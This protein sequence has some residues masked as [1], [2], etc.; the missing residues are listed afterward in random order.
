MEDTQMGVISKETCWSIHNRTMITKRDDLS[1]VLEL[2][3]EYTTYK[4]KNGIYTK[5]TFK[6][7]LPIIFEGVTPAYRFLDLLSYKMECKAI[8]AT[9]Q[10]YNDKNDAF[11]ISSVDHLRKIMSD[12]KIAS[13]LSWSK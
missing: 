2:T 1:N 7:T 5:K 13:S 8:P 11:C 10:Y 3:V 9:H 6:E 4:N 12:E